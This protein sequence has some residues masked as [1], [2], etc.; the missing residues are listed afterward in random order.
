MSVRIFCKCGT[1]VTNEVSLWDRK[2]RTIFWMD[3]NP[4]QCARCRK[5]RVVP[6]AR[7]TETRKKVAAR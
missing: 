5:P 1:E 4:P 2:T 3:Q 6:V 7:A